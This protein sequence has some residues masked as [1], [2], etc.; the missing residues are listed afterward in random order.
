MEEKYLRFP[1]DTGQE[2][3]L[4]KIDTVVPV[5]KN[6]RRLS[7]A[8]M[9]NLSPHESGY[10]NLDMCQDQLSRRRRL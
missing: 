3:V 9:E 1:L 8:T 6:C 7:N 10:W 4:N 5:A 2:D